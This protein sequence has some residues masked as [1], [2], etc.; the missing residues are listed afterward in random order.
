MIT[1]G[2]RIAALRKSRSMTQEEL[3]GIIG[4]SSQAISKWENN[5]TMPD[6]MLLPVIAGVFDITIDA[7]FGEDLNP[8]AFTYDRD[9]LPEKAYDSILKSMECCLN[10]EKKDITMRM[11]DEKV[12]RRKRHLKNVPHSQTGVT[13]SLKKGAVYANH[14]IALAYLQEP[15]QSGALLESDAVADLL[16]VLSMH[17][18]RIILKC[19]IDNPNTTFTASSIAAKNQLD[20]TDAITVLKKL[21]QYKLI[22]SVKLD[23]GTEEILEIYSLFNHYKIYLILYP[24]LSL[25]ERLCYFQDHWNYLSC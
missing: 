24:M 17:P 1:F 2:E 13:D 21:E 15:S 22:H 14:N 25:A 7:L 3:S 5:Q 11:I 8:K 19:M 12:E 16:S 4:V 18:A 10:H 23:V 6:I 20:A 9:L